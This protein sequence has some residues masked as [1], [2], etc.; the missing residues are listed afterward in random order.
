[1]ARLW[2]SRTQLVLKKSWIFVPTYQVKPLLA[3]KPITTPAP[4]GAAF[5]SA[6]RVNVTPTRLKSCLTVT[7]VAPFRYW[8]AIVRSNFGLRQ[9]CGDRGDGLITHLLSVVRCSFSTLLRQQDVPSAMV[10]LQSE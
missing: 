4:N 7:K 10:R 2:I 9:W 1:M 3:V 6:L 8:R 5:S